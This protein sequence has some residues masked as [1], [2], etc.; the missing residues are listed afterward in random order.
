MNTDVAFSH[1]G[2][3]Q[4]TTYQ[5]FF[6]ATNMDT[7]PNGMKTLVYKKNTTTSSPTTTPTYAINIRFSFLLIAVIFMLFGFI[8]KKPNYSYKEIYII[9]K[10]LLFCRIYF[11]Y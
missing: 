10:N 2:L 7:S 9:K 11:F 8:W 4:A 6:G 1:T 5:I 3:T